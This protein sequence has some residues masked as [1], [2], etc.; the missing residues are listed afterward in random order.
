MDMDVYGCSSKRSIA[1]S[2]GS[3]ARRTRRNRQF[4][5]LRTSWERLVTWLALGPAPQLRDC[6]KCGRSGMRD[7]TLCGYCWEKL[8]ELAPLAG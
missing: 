8:P 1:R 4:P 2:R 3:R 6:P 7:A 5:A